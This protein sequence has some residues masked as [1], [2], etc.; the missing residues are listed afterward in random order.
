M[1]NQVITDFFKNILAELLEPPAAASSSASSASPPVPLL[2]V[3][4]KDTKA[5][6][7][8]RQFCRR[9]RRDLVAKYGA[10][11][12]CEPP[13]F[14]VTFACQP[15]TR[16]D[17]RCRS[18]AA[19]SDEADDRDDEAELS[20]EAKSDKI[21][22]RMQRYLAG[23]SAAVELARVV[24]WRRLEDLLGRIG[25]HKTPFKSCVL[26]PNVSAK[27]VTDYLPQYSQN[28]TNTKLVNFSENVAILCAAVPDNQ[29]VV[30]VAS[31]VILFQTFQTVVNTSGSGKVLT[32]VDFGALM[33]LSNSI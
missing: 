17:D 18:Y 1:A 32:A 28:M 16:A 26:A 8:D 4:D 31:L 7:F 25:S 12:D 2:V 33:L 19:A 9:L 5:S 6:F 15:R 10:D 22:R 13:C 20:V 24:K 27:L 29:V 21:F 23:K 3:V 11:D 30:N 14:E